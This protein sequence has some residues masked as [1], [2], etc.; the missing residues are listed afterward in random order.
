MRAPTNSA[1][2]DTARREGR[3]PQRDGAAQDAH[4][5]QSQACIAFLQQHITSLKRGRKYGQKCPYQHSPGSRVLSGLV[6]RCRRLRITTHS[7][8]EHRN[9]KTLKVFI[10]ICL[11]E[12]RHAE[13]PRWVAVAVFHI[14][15]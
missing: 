6:S 11:P 2:L 14:A 1:E 13:P 7:G 9:E 12:G 8:R 10:T 15:T 5:S 4:S 3:S